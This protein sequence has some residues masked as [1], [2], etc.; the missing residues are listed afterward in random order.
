[1]KGENWLQDQGERR[2]GNRDTATGAD[3]ER[4]ACITVILVRTLVL[5]GCLC[6]PGFVSM[7]SIIHTRGPNQVQGIYAQEDDEEFHDVMNHKDNC[8]STNFL[9]I[10]QGRNSALYTT[11][12]SNFSTLGFQS[13]PKPALM[14]R[15]MGLVG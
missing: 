2:N 12:S 14:I 11:K 8:K 13:R 6:G 10:Y 3:A 1:M 7:I 4:G 5:V 9:E 15:F